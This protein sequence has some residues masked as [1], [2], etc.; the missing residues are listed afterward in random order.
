MGLLQGIYGIMEVFA[1]NILTKPE[2]FIGILVFIGYMALARPLHEAIGGFVKGT[3]GFMILGVGAGGLVVT[4]RPILAGLN[5]KF[6]LNAAVIDPYF[7]LNAANKALESIGISTAWTMIALVVGFSFNMLLVLFRKQTKVRTLFITGHILLQQAATITWLVFLGVPSLRNIQGVIVVGLL[8]GT[9]WAVFSNI[10]VEPT[11]K[12]TNGAGFAIGHQQGFGIW[13]ADKFGGKVGNKENSVEDLE[14]P[15]FLEMFNDNV[16]ATGILM[17]AFFG[18]IMVIL[19]E[20]YLRE[21]DSGFGT[22]TAFPFYI[23]GKSFEF[24]V[25]LHILIS[26]VRMFVSE[27]TESFQGISDKILPGAVPAVD[28]A[29]SFAYSSPN[30]VLVGFISGAIGQFIAIAGLVIFESPILIITGFVPVFF[31]NA[32]IA[33]FADKVGGIKAATIFPFFSG[34]L[35]VLGGAF[36]AGAFGLYEYGGWHGNFDF[37]TIWPFIGWGIQEM[38]IAFIGI[39]IIAMLLIPQ[40]QY[41]N[42]K[43]NYFNIMQSEDEAA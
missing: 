23:I 14:L 1:Q 40:F 10:T 33:V 11:Q 24:A 36:A 6:G 39:S 12:L 27:L 15:G 3:V 20:P 32:T 30:T 5:G 21:I 28:C 25:Y 43:E 17:L 4:F 7:G 26:G 16:I 29:A 8:A 9:Y 19:G 22:D 38:S 31:D 2:F 34:I 35:Q 37:A 42:N 18:T 41:R 13:L